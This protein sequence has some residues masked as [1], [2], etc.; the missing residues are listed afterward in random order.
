M[1]NVFLLVKNMPKKGEGLESPIGIRL[2]KNTMNTVQILADSYDLSTSYV[3]RKLTQFAVEL[4]K[5]GIL[6]FPQCELNKTELKKL[7]EK[8]EE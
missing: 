7:L 4:W 8:E 6:I 2:D 5:K 3:I 1:H